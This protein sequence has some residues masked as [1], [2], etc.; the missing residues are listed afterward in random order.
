MRIRNRVHTA[1]CDYCGR[2]IAWSVKRRQW[3]VLAP[4]TDMAGTHLRRRLMCPKAPPGKT[5]HD[6]K[7]SVFDRMYGLLGGEA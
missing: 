4:F 2:K 1:R 6:P 5:F 3:L 7:A